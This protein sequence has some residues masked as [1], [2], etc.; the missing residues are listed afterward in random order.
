MN[1]DSLPHRLR[2]ST[3]R[4][5]EPTLKTAVDKFP[6]VVRV[7]PSSYGL[8][9]S[10]VACR[11]RDAKFSLLKYHWETTLNVAKFRN[12]AD[13]FAVH[14]RE[15]GM[16]E[17]GPLQ[18]VC[19]TLIEPVEVMSESALDMTET[20]L[21]EQLLMFTL[22]HERALGRPILLSMSEEARVQALAQYDIALT[23]FNGNFILT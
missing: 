5:Y 21:V 16:V 20:G 19:P 12:I 4:R 1:S 13:Q 10:T 14:Q 6:L 9:A 17:L 7:D 11:L 15:D 2:E 3:F 23:P 8:S 18:R 22:A